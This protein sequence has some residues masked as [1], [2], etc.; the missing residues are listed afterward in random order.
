M[1]RQPSIFVFILVLTVPLAAQEKETIFE[2][3]F[4]GRL[5]EGWVWKREN[6]KGYRFVRSKLEVLMEPFADQEARN[7]L[8]R[9]SPNRK[10]G[11]YQIE[12]QFDAEMPFENQFQQVGIFWMQDEKVVFKFVREMIDGN[13]YIFPGKIPIE[14]ESTFLRLT[15]SGD[16]VVAEFK[17]KEDG[18]YKPAFEGKLPTYAEGESVGIQCWHGPAKKE[19]WV[20]LRRFLIFKHK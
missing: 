11:T 9:L 2:D 15:V 3:K 5:K 10:S 7:V 17:T 19:H 18:E 8:S 6:P 20:K 16:N 4:E 14:G 12:L 13:V 1:L